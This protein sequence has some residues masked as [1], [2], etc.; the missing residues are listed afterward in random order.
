[1]GVT[2]QNGS[3]KTTLL[4]VCCEAMVP[5]SG[6]VDISGLV[7][8]F[9]DIRLGLEEDATGYENIILKGSYLERTPNFLLHF[10][11]KLKK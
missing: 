3:G 5:T 2:G 9:I 8:P 11:K 10:L 1:M 6:K 7:T 4:R